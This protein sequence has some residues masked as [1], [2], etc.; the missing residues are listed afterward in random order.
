MDDGDREEL[1]H[2]QSLADDDDFHAGDAPN[3]PDMVNIDGFLTGAERADLSHAGGE[4]GSLEQ[5]I[6]E[7]L[8]E[9]DKRRGRYG[10][11]FF[12][13]SLA[14]ADM[15]RSKREDWRTHRD[16]TELR[17]RAFSSQMPEIVSAYIRMCAE[18]EM[19]ARPRSDDDQEEEIYEIQVVDMF[20]RFFGV[21]SSFVFG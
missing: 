7:D 6:E 11:H 5:D 12:P 9:E 15:R 19:P 2:L 14:W 3:F 10:S 1:S 21:R 20:G 18:L 13:A 16:H 17:N 8:V 4:L